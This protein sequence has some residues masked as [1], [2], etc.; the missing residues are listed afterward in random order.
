MTIDD[1][2]ARYGVTLLRVALGILFL[3]HAGLKLLVFGPA[4]TAAFFASLGLPPGLAYL[5]MA[6][7]IAGGLALVLGV[8]ARI[9][10]LLLMPLLLGTIVTVHG[11]N[12]FFFSN[13]HGGWEFPA[14]WALALLVQAMLGDGAAALVP[15]RWGARTDAD[16]LASGQR[17]PAA[18]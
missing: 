10:A 1:R 5:T 2:T 18:G 14:F 7:E 8:Y 16:L 12:G 9:A 3:A 13:P 6:A 4:G 11:A 15:T 17:R